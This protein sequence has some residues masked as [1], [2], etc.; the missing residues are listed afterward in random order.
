MALLADGIALHRHHTYGSASLATTID[1]FR[2]LAIT[3]SMA[4]QQ[5]QGIQTLLE[6]EKEA[7]KI[8]QK[9]R[10]YRTQ[11]L[12]DARSEAS[13]EI[14]QL[15]SK[16]E[17]EFNDFQKE[18]EGSTSS[19]QTTVDKE[20][21]QR[22]EEL[23]KAFESNRDEVIKKLLDR[24]VDVKTELHRNLQLQQKQQKA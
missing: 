4:A 17:K 14:E 1:S 23:N 18:H 13:K 24:V 9:A 2:Q 12:K 7:A 19:S 15:K 16:K 6:A 5:S 3:S 22:L 11:K 8:V 20:T 21:E 10:T